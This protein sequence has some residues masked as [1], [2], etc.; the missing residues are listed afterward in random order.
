MTVEQHAVETDKHPV[1]D[2]A[3]PMDNGAMGDG[4]EAA[5]GNRRAAFRVDHHA[6]LNIG[7]R[8]DHD[9]FHISGRIEFVGTDHRVRP[10]VDKI[11]DNHPA[12]DYRGRIDIGL[13]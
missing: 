12:A 2:A 5:D 8:A 13:R 3:W 10:N 7:M 1:F 4:A 9:R 6:I 11:L